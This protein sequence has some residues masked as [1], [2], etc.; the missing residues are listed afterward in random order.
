MYPSTGL[1]ILCRLFGKTRQGW[2]QWAA[3]LDESV[4]F[5]S[6]IVQM[7]IDIR[8]Q[9]NNL[10]LGTSK[11]LLLIN[12]QLAKQSMRIGRDRL[13]GILRE[14]GL[15]VRRR[16]RSISTTYSNHMLRRYANLIKDKV[17]TAP[18]QVWASDITYVRLKQGFAY[19]S[20]ITDVYSRKI[21]GYCLHPTLSALGPQRALMMAFT[22]RIYPK[23]ELVHHSDQGIQYCSY[24]YV[25][26]LKSNGISISM[27]KKGSPQENAIAER[28][29]GILKQEYSLGKTFA[30][31]EE[32][33]KVVQL[34]IDSYNEKRP[35][36]SLDMQTPNQVHQQ[37]CAQEVLQMESENR[38]NF[39]S[40]KQDQ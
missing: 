4:L 31:I 26:L 33:Q 40:V 17:L 1:A 18:E 11:L 8:Q 27:S 29:N 30:S 7:A 15:L 12:D 25:Q 9:M 38:N 36:R 19:L 10:K 37:L 3:G 5:E 2:Y 13:Y 35:H 22:Q 21:M 34:G 23:S 32:A 6:L 39:T 20:L 28:V 24:E 16:K 14:A